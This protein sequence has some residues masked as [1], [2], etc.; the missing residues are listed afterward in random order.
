MLVP[1]PRLQEMVFVIRPNLV[2]LLKGDRKSR[3]STVGD[4]DVVGF[5]AAKS[6]HP[7]PRLV[8]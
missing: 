6:V 3:G 5:E 4:V 7:S 1:S 8:T 2:V